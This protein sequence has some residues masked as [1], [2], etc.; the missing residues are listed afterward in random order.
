MKQAFFLIGVS[1]ALALSG[2]NGQV[3]QNN[4]AFNT[5]VVT[6]GGSLVDY[7][8]SMT[9]VGGAETRVGFFTNFDLTS[10]VD[11]PPV[12]VRLGNLPAHGKLWTAHAVDFQTV[13]AAPNSPALKCAAQKHPGTVLTYR[14]ETGYAGEDSFTYDVFYPNGMAMHVVTAVHVQ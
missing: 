7:T 1:A 13:H 14:A 11:G 12:L 10:C 3:Q 5:R 9:V 2:C 8:R 4:A 6:N